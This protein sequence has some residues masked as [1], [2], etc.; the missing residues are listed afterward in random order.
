MFKLYFKKLFLI[1]AFLF[2]ILGLYY[3]SWPI[4]VSFSNFFEYPAIRYTILMGIPTF[5]MLMFVNRRRIENQSLRVDYIKYVRNLST[6]DLKLNIKN[7]LNYFKTFKPLHAEAI[8]F[9]TL[10]LPFVIGIGITIE[11]DAPFLINCL[12]GLIVFSLFIC[13]YLVLD[14][15]LWLLVHRSWLK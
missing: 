10:I 6:A 14:I 1:I 8:A 2:L 11:N 9:A 3:I 5:L 15:A 4:L 12:V 13:I 7:E